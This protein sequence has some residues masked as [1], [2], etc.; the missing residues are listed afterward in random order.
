MAYRIGPFE[1]RPRERKL[2]RD[3]RE[4]PLGARG[5]EILM[6]LIEADGD[7]VSKEALLTRVW[8]GVIVNE[9]NLHTQISAVRKALGESGSFVA[10][11]PG[12]GYRFAGPIEMVEAVRSPAVIVERREADRPSIAVLPFENLSDDSEQGYFADGM[13]EE[14]ITALSRM[15]WLFVI[16][17]NSSFAHRARGADASRFAEELGVRYVVT[18]SVRRALRRLRITC[19]LVDA[20]SQMEIWAD[21]FDGEMEDVFDLQD[22]VTA[23][24]VG[25]IEPRL[26]Q[27]EVERARAKPTQDLLAYDHYLRALGHLV[28]R[29][30]ENF[31]QALAE[32][33]SALALDGDFALALALA[34][35]CRYV[36][37]LEG[38]IAEPEVE[39]DAMAQLAEAAL[40]RGPDDATVLSHAG[41]VLAWCGRSLPA[42][43]QLVDRATRLN[44]NSA[45]GVYVDGWVRMQAGRSDEAIERF[46]TSIALS[47][48]DPLS[49]A[50]AMAATGQALLLAGRHEEAVRWAERAIRE[51]AD[52]GYAHRVRVA[53]LAL[54]GRVDAATAAARTLLEIEPGFTVAGFLKRLPIR[55]TPASRLLAEGLRSA[56]LP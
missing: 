34:A 13:A 47:P 36:R 22:R 16:A 5:F 29:T 11:A 4:V 45:Y 56:G 54:T 33:D 15:R 51:A 9:N 49:A 50:S 46:Q 44:P 27:V 41:F 3:G 35:H 14:L 25:A 2:L 40:A 28:P 48:L 53:A 39:I 37:L 23:S 52:L 38:W 8:P 6:G 32:L 7:V 21:R 18:G 1:L 42:S 10:N 17:R 26:R 24:I 12:R 20:Q 30:A 43:L 19:H 55:D 31:E